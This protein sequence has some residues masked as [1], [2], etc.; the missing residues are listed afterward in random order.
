MAKKEILDI[1]SRFKSR[2]G[3]TLSIKS[4]ILFGSYANGNPKPGSDI[5]I[6]VIVDKIDGDYLETEAS[7][8]KAGRETDERIEPILIIGSSDPSGFYQNIRTYG[9]VIV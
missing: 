9:E 4:V 5:D 3:K 7:L 8:W 1:A 2:L 6:A